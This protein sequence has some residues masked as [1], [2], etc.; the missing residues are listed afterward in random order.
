MHPIVARIAA[1]WHR[2]S[3]PLKMFSFAS[4][5]VVNVLVDLSIFTISIKVFHFPLI[6]SN[7]LAWLVAVTGSYI[8]NTK[9]T[10]GR[11][12][13]GHLSVGHY[14]R[15]TVSGILGV[16]VATVVLV[17]LSNHT[18]IAVA[19]FVSIAVGFVVNF[20][21]SHFVVFRAPALQS[22]RS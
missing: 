22:T 6:A 1:A 7:I 3:L 21:M 4:I 20:C 17:A 13:G 2:R 15:F 10:F 16:V 18:N 12:T 5:G 8:M 11:E 14:L 19:K 9:V